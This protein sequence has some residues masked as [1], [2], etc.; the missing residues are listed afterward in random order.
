M[1]TSCRVVCTFLQRLPHEFFARDGKDH[2]QPG[3]DICTI[4]WTSSLSQG[5]S[6]PVLWSPLRR[7]PTPLPVTELAFG[8]SPGRRP[9]PSPVAKKGSVQAP[10]SAASRQ[11]QRALSISRAGVASTAFRRPSSKGVERPRPRA[12]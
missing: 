2:V 1:A 11:L 7:Q 10:T 4:G 6:E 12:F 9:G 3:C 8:A 5:L